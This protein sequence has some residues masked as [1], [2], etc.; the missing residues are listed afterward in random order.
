MKLLPIVALLAACSPA[1]VLAESIYHTFTFS[2]AQTDYAFALNFT[3]GWTVGSIGGPAATDAD[4]Q[5]VLGG[6]TEFRVGASGTAVPT[7]NGNATIGFGLFTPNLGGVASDTDFLS[8]P[9]FCNNWTNTGNLPGLCS[10]VAVA[11]FSNSF[12]LTQVDFIAPGKYLGNDIA[13]FNNSLTFG[14]IGLP[15]PPASYAFRSGIVVLTGDS[16]VPEPASAALG[17]LGLAA[18]VGLRAAVAQASRPVI[19]SRSSDRA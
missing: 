2:N 4:I 12:V 15:N 8:G 1:T 3:G 11:A 17:L 7:T 6:L 10:N 13:A 19:P 18:I 5:K 16:A 9:G 14:W